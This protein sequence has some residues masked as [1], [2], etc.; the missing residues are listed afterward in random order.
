MR[1][2]IQLLTDKGESRN[3]IIRYLSVPDD[4]NQLSG[5]SIL[6]ISQE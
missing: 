3:L 2:I 1:N 6:N 4:L 5:T